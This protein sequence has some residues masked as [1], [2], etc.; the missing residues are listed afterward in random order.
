MRQ[1]KLSSREKGTL[2]R[3]ICMSLR[4]IEMLGKRVWVHFTAQDMIAKVVCR[5][6]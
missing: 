5:W 4:A 3:V 1:M 6:L 2:P